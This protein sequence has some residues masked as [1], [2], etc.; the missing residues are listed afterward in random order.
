MAADHYQSALKSPKAPQP[1]N[2]KAALCFHRLGLCNEAAKLFS[3]YFKY[4]FEN[5]ECDT[6]VLHYIQ[7]VL[8][9]VGSRRHGIE[10]C[11]LD[12]QFGSICFAVLGL[13]ARKGCRQGPGGAFIQHFWLLRRFS[14]PNFA[15]FHSS[16][17]R[18]NYQ[19]IACLIIRTQFTAENYYH[20]VEASPYSTTPMRK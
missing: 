11:H 9:I 14:R 3:C 8:L 2:K 12:H 18:W 19:S 1:L 7:E 4:L 17:V 15:K 13:E 16:L 20:F 6:K 10:I 5:G